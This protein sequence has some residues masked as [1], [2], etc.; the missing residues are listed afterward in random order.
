MTKIEY[1][2]FKDYLL[3]EFKDFSAEEIKEAFKKLS[4]NKLEVDESHFGKLSPMY[5]GKV[6]TSYRAF[7]HKQLSEEEKNKPR[8]KNEPTEQELHEIRKNYVHTCFVNPFNK[9]KQTGVNHFAQDD[10]AYFFKY[11]LHYE[12]IQIS[13]EEA[14]SYKFK[15]LRIIGDTARKLVDSNKEL[16]E[17]KKKLEMIVDG[18]IDNIELVKRKAAALLRGLVQ[19]ID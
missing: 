9:L 3:K 11:L 15:A 17:L 16:R 12:I 4:A 1:D 19:G 18:E 13:K 8:M 6:L 14:E 2:V 7:R 10:A 5:L